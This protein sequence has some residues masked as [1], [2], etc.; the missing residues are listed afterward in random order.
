MASSPDELAIIRSLREERQG[1]KT[2]LDRL[3]SGV[4]GGTSGGMEDRVTR[5]ETHVEYLRRDS[6]EVR[7]TLRS[8]EQK[9]GTVATKRDLESWR[10]QWVG[11][12]VA[13]TALVATVITGS[14]G[15]LTWIMEK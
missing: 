5:L 2:E 10:W 1:L 7:G 12:L 4:G 11:F 13:A 14:L 15:F 8:I 9:L 3:K 6:D